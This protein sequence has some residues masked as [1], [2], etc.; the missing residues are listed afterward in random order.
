MVFLRQHLNR[1]FLLHFNSGISPVRTHQSASTPSPLAGCQNVLQDFL[2]DPRRQRLNL[3][4]RNKELRAKNLV[5]ARVL[6]AWIDPVS[7]AGRRNNNLVKNAKN[8]CEQVDDTLYSRPVMNI[9]QSE[10][11]FLGGDKGKANAKGNLIV[12]RR[13]CSI[14]AV[15]QETKEILEVPLEREN[16]ESDHV[17]EPKMKLF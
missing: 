5:P 7:S 11:S 16:N 3:F 8:I 14:N 17:K 9:T 10:S 2:T 6:G 4:F 12:F 13:M 1:V 15:V